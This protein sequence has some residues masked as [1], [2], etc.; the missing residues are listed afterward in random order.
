MTIGDKVIITNS[1]IKE[2]N[3]KKGVI[4][5]LSYF[6]GDL[7]IWITVTEG[8]HLRTVL[9]HEGEVKVEE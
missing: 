2:D 6:E 1:K 8:I 3:G 5:E 7:E 4:K 9:C